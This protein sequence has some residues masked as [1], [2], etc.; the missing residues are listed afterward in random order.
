MN[1][2]SWWAAVRTHMDLPLCVCAS[3]CSVSC[4]AYAVCGIRVN[5]QQ[6]AGHHLVWAPGRDKGSRRPLSGR[7][8]QSVGRAALN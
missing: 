7:G 4:K 1:V 8:E 6:R 3:V 2:N 5:P